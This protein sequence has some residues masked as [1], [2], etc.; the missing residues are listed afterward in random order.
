MLNPEFKFDSRLYIVI[1]NIVEYEDVKF[2]LLQNVKNTD[3]VLGIITENSLFL[4]E[5]KLK[6]YNIQ[7]LEDNILENKLIKE[8]Y[9]LLIVNSTETLVSLKHLSWNLYE[10]HNCN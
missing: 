2:N 7:K 8:C 1:D 9:D 5:N 3:N 6:I 10:K 4:Q